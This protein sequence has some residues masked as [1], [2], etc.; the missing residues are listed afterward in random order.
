MKHLHTQELI[1]SRELQLLAFL[2]LLLFWV[3]QAPASCSCVSVTD[4]D[5]DGISDSDETLS[6]LR[7]L[8]ADP[9][10]KD[11]F[12]ECDYMQ[13]KVNRD[14]DTTDLGEH[15]HGLKPEAVWT[16]R[17]M[18]A[19]AP[20]C[21]P[22]GRP[23]I[24]LHIVQQPLKIKTRSRDRSARS[25]QHFL[26]MT[27][28]L[29]GQSFFD[30][31]RK[32]FK[33]RRLAPYFHYCIL[34]HNAAEEYG[35]ISG[36]AEV[37]GNDF[38]VT[39]GSWPDETG[40]PVGTIADQV[41][42]FM[43]ELG[44]NLAL[45]HGGPPSLS[46]SQQLVN[47]K[48]NYLSVMSYSFQVAS[49]NGRFDYSRWEA[50]TLDELTLTESAG[51]GHYEP[52]RYVC[53]NDQMVRS[54]LPEGTDLFVDWNCNS[55]S[56]SGLAQ[57]LNFD[58]SGRTAEPLLDTLAGANDWNDI[59]YAFQ[60]SPLYDSD[61]PLARQQHMQNPGLYRPHV[62][63][64]ELGIDRDPELSAKE[65]RGIEV[66]RVDPMDLATEVVIPQADADSDGWGNAND[67]CP[68]LANAGQQDRDFDGVGDACDNCPDIYNPE[69]TDTDSDTTGDMC[70]YAP[71]SALAPPQVP[72]ECQTRVCTLTAASASTLEV[73]D[74]LGGSTSTTEPLGGNV[75]VNVCGTASAGFVLGSAMPQEIAVWPGGSGDPLCVHLRGINAYCDCVAGAGPAHYD[76]CIDG[77]LGDGDQCP[78]PTFLSQELLPA[79]GGNSAVTLTPSGATASGACAGA[80]AIA[81]KQLA[82]GSFGTDATPC[83]GDD[84]AGYS[85][86]FPTFFTT[87]N[88]GAQL[89]DAAGFVPS[90]LAASFSGSAVTCTSLADGNLSGLSLVATTPYLNMGGGDGIHRFT[91][92]CQ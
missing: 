47:R 38:M 9:N 10:H 5:G 16:L 69:Q 24:A 90:D 81:L 66:A 6:I 60:D 71:L 63:T 92:T 56:N 76:T 55:G 23:G 80:F 67:N 31:K 58:R 1:R 34:A 15:S 46:A 86:P 48:P 49:I 26:D 54:P 59:D 21:N 84:T 17:A 22:D 14:R 42:T 64:S 3:P 33:Y 8:G 32:N 35:S 70:E 18:F 27:S 78:A 7:G 73:P 87:G 36:V 57:N 41:G 52:T 44:H 37:G 74:N 72:S 11:I 68:A 4:C 53:P 30:L 2:V 79:G 40:A 12:V 77:D 43:H 50:P 88:A 39:L 75:L 28:R 62:E 29:W 13:F 65:G 91:L 61:W 89:F 51:S 82:P 20:V 19:N 25:E 85:D 83:T 45:N